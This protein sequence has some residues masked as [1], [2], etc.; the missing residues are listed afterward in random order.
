MFPHTHLRGI[1][2]EY[3][4]IYPDGREERIL[5]VPEYDFNWQTYY[6]F[7]KP[8]AVPAGAKIVS[9]AWY[10]NSPKNPYNPSYNFV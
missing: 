8:L 2:W 7:A 3:T 9:S 4:L 5:D 6:M 1:R 10:D